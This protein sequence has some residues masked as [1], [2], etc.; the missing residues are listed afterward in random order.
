MRREKKGNAIEKMME[1]GAVMSPMS[2]ITDMPFRRMIKKFGCAFAFTEMVD[3]NSIYYGNKKAFRYLEKGEDDPCL[4]VQITG[5]DPE[6]IIPVAEI[7]QEKGFE[8]LD[9]NAG[10]PVRKVVKTGKGAA[11]L[12]EPEKLGMI[13]RMLV[14]ALRIPVTVKIRS[15]WDK[16]SVNC[17]EVAKVIEAAGA[18][19]I[20]VHPRTREQMYKGRPDYSAVRG[21]KQNAG[22]PVFVSGNMFNVE[23][24]GKV[25]NETGCDGVFIARGALGKPW[26]FRDLDKFFTTGEKEESIPDFT[27][28]KKTMLEQFRYNVEYYGE[29]L[30]QKRMYKHMCW[31]LK[32]RKKLDELMKTFRKV[33]TREEAEAFIANIELDEKGRLHPRYVP[34]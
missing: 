32:K 7:C 20:C 3:V 23:N 11:L 26:I 4:G 15:G 22:I 16:R 12:K 28:I 25:M 18:S 8:I 21:I 31:F 29:D 17:L 33:N 14:G 30:G 9:F 2:G 27:F 10:C 5:Q 1:A 6:K 24:I 13:I 19:A 34:A